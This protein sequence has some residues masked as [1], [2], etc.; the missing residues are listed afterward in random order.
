VLCPLRGQR[1]SIS[2][3]RQ[4]PAPSALCDNVLNHTYWRASLLRFCGE[5][6][7][8]P[9]CVSPIDFSAGSK[10]QRHVT[11]S[12]VVRGIPHCHSDLFV[13]ELS[14]QELERYSSPCRVNGC[15]VSV[16]VDRVVRNA[17]QPAWLHGPPLDHEQQVGD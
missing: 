15:G 8:G 5:Y 9:A 3:R 7:T 10:M 12:R 6:R 11:A 13:P 4:I 16:V 17:Y 14:L 2:P 1:V